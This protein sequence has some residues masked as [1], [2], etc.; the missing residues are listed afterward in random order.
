MEDVANMLS[1]FEVIW[2][3]DDKQRSS[4]ACWTQ[5]WIYCHSCHFLCQQT[6]Q[7][8]LAPCRGLVYDWTSVIFCYASLLTA[9]GR[10]FVFQD[11]WLNIHRN[12]W[13]ARGVAAVMCLQT[14]WFS[15]VI[16]KPVTSSSLFFWCVLT[17][18]CHVNHVVVPD[19]H[20]PCY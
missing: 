10:W 7:G 8:E 18:D 9:G 15:S 3:P 1:M 19:W 2:F 12:A 14:S 20:P 4:S 17:S 16:F 13:F 5:F 11:K 6:V